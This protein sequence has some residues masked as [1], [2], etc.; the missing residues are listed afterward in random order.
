MLRALRRAVDRRMIADVPVG[1]LLSGGLDSSLIVALLAEH[2]Q[3]G[4]QTFSV[5]FESAGEIEG[6]EF[7]YS[8]LVAREFGTRH[9]REVVSNERVLPTLPKA[10]EAMSEPMT[11]HDVV[12]FYLLSQEVAK[13]VTVVQSGQGADEVFAGYDWYPPL[14]EAEGYGSSVYRRAF[15][16]RSHEEIAAAVAPEHQV[17]RDVSRAFV[18]GQF[19]EVGADEPLDR[20]LRL[21]TSVMLVEDPVK[22]VDNMT[23]A[24]GLEGRVPFLDHEVVDL[25]AAIPPSLKAADEGKGVIKGVARGVV[26][27]RGDRPPKGYLGARADPPG[28]RLPGAGEGRAVGPGGARARPVPAVLRGRAPVGAQRPP[29]AARIEQA[30]AAGVARARLQLHDL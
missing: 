14:D 9:E 28:G 24:W 26:P 20:A 15:V 2:G 3:T 11:S 23:M 12:A 16:D 5:G 7:E 8:D 30:V 21:D 6:D 19:L 10:I 27:G 1:V 13:H 29:D 17:E 18:E 25:A 4:L 22:R